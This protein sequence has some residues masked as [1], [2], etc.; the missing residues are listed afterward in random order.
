MYL[1]P[2]AMDDLVVD[3]E[4]TTLI[5]DDKY[6]NAAAAVV[7]GVCQAV[8]EAA[9]VKNRK[10]LLDITSLGHG[11]DTAVITDVENAVLLEDWADHV[12]D[13][14]GWAWV[15]HKGALLMQ[16]LGEEVDTEVA[17]LASLCRGGDADDLART[18][19]EDEEVTNADVMAW[20]GDG[21]WRS[22]IAAAGVA[23][24]G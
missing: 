15:A 5:T 9:L 11:D 17:V 12:L 2:A 14:N 7:E 22:G 20:D 13:N 16:L 10:T 8:E 6:T 18:S 21:V 24:L 23:T 3:G 1:Q 4:L 19:L